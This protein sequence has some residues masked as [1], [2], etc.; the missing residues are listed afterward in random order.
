MGAIVNEKILIGI[1][2]AHQFIPIAITT[3]NLQLKHSRPTY[4]VSRVLMLTNLKNSNTIETHNRLNP[5][6]I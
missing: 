3:P 4:P 2:M 6:V 5:T 1:E